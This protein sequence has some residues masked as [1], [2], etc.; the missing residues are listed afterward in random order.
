MSPHDAASPPTS[1]NLSALKGGEGFTPIAAS[2]FG[3]PGTDR[4]LARDSRAMHQAAR[5]VVVVD[6]IVHGAAVVP[7]RER[8]GLPAEAAGEFRPGAV[9]VE[10]IEQ[11]PALRL[12]HV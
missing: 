5:A 4:A 7:D 11:R 9:L 3:P 6:G 1:P 2:N 8:A 10:E 12:A